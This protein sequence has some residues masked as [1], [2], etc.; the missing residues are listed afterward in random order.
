MKIGLV[1]LGDVL[2]DPAT[3]RCVTDAQRHR[4]IVEQAVLAESVGFDAVHLGEHHGSGYQLSAPAVVLAAIGERTT[5]LT[6]STGVTLVAN[7]DPVRVAED[8]ATVDVLSGGRAEIVAGRGSL[9][10]RTFEYLGQDSRQSRPLYNEHVALLVKL[11]REENVSHPGPLRAPL[12]GFTSRPRPVADLPLW[13]GGGLNAETPTLAGQL[14][15]PLML[16][17]VFAPP[18]AFVPHIEAYRQ[19]YA[20]SGHPGGPRLGAI[21]HCHVDTTGQGARSAFEPHYRQYWEWVQELV[22]AYTPRARSLPFDYEKMLAGP[23]LCGS[24]AEVIDRV[25][26]WKAALPLP[27]ERFGFMFDLGG[28]PEDRLRTTIERF[29]ADVAPHIK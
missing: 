2:P 22:Q 21:C 3:G 29:G 11:L 14:G 10:A 24:P 1:S 15:L 12:D 27:L 19:A 23:A 18:D 4:S 28:M 8:Y 17:S 25:G 13:L 7:L 5:T 6:L 20:D 9:F 26:Q 16:P